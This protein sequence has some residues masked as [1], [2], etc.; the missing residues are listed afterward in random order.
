MQSQ[1]KFNL[2]LG[3]PKAFLLIPC[4]PMKNLLD[5]LLVEENYILLHIRLT[6]N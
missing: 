3:K 2:S 5:S 1:C 6:K 4:L